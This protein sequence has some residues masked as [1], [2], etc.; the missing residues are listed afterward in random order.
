MI[1]IYTRFLLPEDYGTLEMLD[2]FIS[3]FGI[4][5]FIAIR[6]A[7]TRIYYD[8]MVVE[9]QKEV[10]STALVS[11]LI[12]CGVA[13][14][15]SLNFSCGISQLIFMNKNH[16]NLVTLVLITFYLQTI[17]DIGF[18]YLQIKQQSGFFTILSV[19]KV[20]I[21]LSLNILFL[22][23]L[24][25]G[26]Y[27]L[28]LGGL[29]SSVLMALYFFVYLTFETKLKFSKT[30]L[31]Q[32]L[33]FGIPL[34]PANMA[35]F[36][37]NSVDRYL[38]NYFSSLAA[39]GIYSLSYKFGMLI[40]IMIT[41]PFISIWLPKRLEISRQHNAKR[42]YALVTTYY[43]LIVCFI[44]L[45]LSVFS[46]ELILIMADAAYSDA[47]KY[48]GIIAFSYVISGLVYHYNIG[49]HI[50][51]QTKY[52][53]YINVPT[54][55]INVLL[56]LVLIP[57]FFIW[58]AAISTI[59]SF[60]FRSLC[61]YLVN[62]KIFPI[63]FET[64]RMFKIAFACII[65]YGISFQINFHSFMLNIL[66]KFNLC[67]FFF[68]VL[69]LFRFFTEQEIQQVKLQVIKIRNLKSLKTLK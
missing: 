26:V 13:V 69:F 6:S 43:F 35:T 53:S 37:V 8:Y 19:I 41:G 24:K 39:V 49:M 21:Q 27:G 17:S 28:L 58:G 56:N 4:L 7:I 12:I 11:T 32:L 18:A 36:V 61:Y 14:G 45:S 67:L 34:V 66:I 68:V 52:V 25:K 51:K 22:V 33:S 48:I 16:C 1:P 20:F 62:Q 15:V 2:F 57:R 29:I 55:I 42:I 59:I 31:K 9:E 63:P 54:A 23:V 46:R 50:R 40:Q 5:V 44:A 38:L 30:K 65:V 60:V 10:I 3:M 47:Y 64:I